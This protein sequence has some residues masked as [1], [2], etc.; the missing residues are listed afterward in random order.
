MPFNS[1]DDLRA[2]CTSLPAG[3]EA[4]ATAALARQDTLTK[5]Q[6]SLGRLEE[7][8]AWLARWQGRPMPRLDKVQVVVFAGSHG[9]TAQGVSAF[10]VRG[11][12]PDGGEFRRRWRG[13]QP[14]GPPGGCGALGG[15]AG[16]R[17]ADRATS[18]RRRPWT[19]PSSS[20]LCRLAT[21]RLR[22]TPTSLCFG[23]MGIGNTTAASAI[24]AALFGGEPANWVG[25]GT[26]VD[27]AGL[28]RKAAAIEMGW[29]DIGAA[30]GDPLQAAAAL[31]GRELAAIMGATL[32]ARHRNVPVLLDGFVCTAAAAPLLKLDPTGLA[33]AMA[34]HVS[35][36]A[37]HRALLAAL[38]LKPLL[39]LGMRLGEGSGACPG[40]Q[41]R[42]RRARLPRRHGE[43]RGSRCFGGVKKGPSGVERFQR[44]HD[45]AQFCKALQPADAGIAGIH[46]LADVVDDDVAVVRPHREAASR[47][48]PRPCGGVP[49]QAAPR[50]PRPCRCRPRDARPRGTSRPAP[51]SRCADARSECRTRNASPSRAGRSWRS[52]RR[53][54]CKG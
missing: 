49:R 8:A 48:S 16:G 29:R 30:L 17:A 14:A 12:A 27:D 51:W 38:G 25:R 6:G 20:A 35:A 18:R 4:A 21:R 24:A 11:D 54:R 7:V 39:D 28:K 10:P 44:A 19:R 47:H 37:G 26:G 9:V 41:R 2:A 1:L 53:S 45:A 43:L 36:E 40:D 32:A 22:R 31:G 3:D 42:A 23:E 33:H 15:A 34:A 46:L 52:L 5:P 13:D 50:R